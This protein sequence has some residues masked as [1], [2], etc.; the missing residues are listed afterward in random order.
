[1]KPL[2]V[3]GNGL[4]LAMGLNTS[5]QD[6]YDY[7][8]EQPSYDEIIVALKSSMDEGR[9]DTWANM[10]LGLGQF[11]SLCPDETSF[12]RCLEDIRFHLKVFL[13]EQEKKAMEMTG[14]Y[15]FLFSPWA[16]VEPVYNQ[17]IQDFKSMRREGN[18]INIVTLN[19][20][21][22][23]ERLLTINRPQTAKTNLLHL[24][25]TLGS[26]VMGVNDTSQ[27]ANSQ[28]ASSGDFCEEFMKPVYN[29][30]C[31]NNKNKLF[32]EMIDYSNVFALYG[33]SLGAS[34]EKWWHAIGSRLLSKD[35]PAILFYFP[36]DKEKDVAS[37]QNYLRRWTK[38]YFMELMGK[39]GIAED[40]ISGSIQNRVYIGINKSFLK[41]V[42]IPKPS[43]AHV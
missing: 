12:V 31:L 40:Q 3:I 4:D 7:Y 36:F 43:R 39:L 42:N 25:G 2:F 10:E 1:M 6:F 23:I 24:H 22:S 11:T 29:D 32:S 34:D 41:P 38:Q 8:K 26:M 21:S 16:F 13:S 27:I 15:T 20:T 9:R 33:T 19:Y 35:D 18:T 37:H 5:Y 30:A 28:F 14:F 17:S